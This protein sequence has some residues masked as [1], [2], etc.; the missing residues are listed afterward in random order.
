MIL[1]SGGVDGGTTSHVA[2]LAGL[3]AAS[4]PRSRHGA[5]SRPADRLRRQRRRTRRW[6]RTGSAIRARA[7]GGGEPAAGPRARGARP[8][9][10]G[11]PR[12]LP[13]ARDGAR[14]RATAS[15]SSW[16]TS[17]SS[18]PRAAA[19]RI[20][21]A[22]RGASG[23]RRGRRRR[24]RGDHRRLL[25]PRRRVPPQRLGESRHFLLDVERA[26]RGGRRGDPP[27]AP[28]RRSTSRILR[29]RIR[30]KM[31]RPTT[32][33][34]TWRTSGSSTPS[35]A[36][37]YGSRWARTRMSRSSLRGVQTERTI[38]DVFRRPSAGGALGPLRRV[39]I[40][41]GSGGVLSHAPRRAQAAMILIDVVEPEG[42]HADRRRLD[43]RDAAPRRARGARTRPP[44]RG[45]RDGTA[46]CP[47]G[48]ARPRPAPAARGAAA[49]RVT[50]ESPGGRVER[51]VGFGAIEVIPLG[52]GETARLR[53]EPAK[54]LDIGAGPGA[55]VDAEVAGGEVGL[56]VDARRAA[57]G[58]SGGL[59]AARPP[60]RGV[61]RRSRSLPLT[62]SPGPSVRAFPPGRLTFHYRFLNQR[63]T[64]A[65]SVAMARR[66]IG[67]CP[68][69]WSSRQRGGS[70][71]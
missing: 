41:I 26:G 55:A 44:P 1:L 2:E 45:L 61:G 51:T 34:Q 6:S 70:R 9:A 20:E 71:R 13:R 24:R 31:V 4:N 3:I 65:P 38:S 23:R 7:H 36:R 67:S 28:R 47:S 66:Q 35:R 50:G 32:I 46:S 43:L 37:R 8:R 53:F 17:P 10:A 49:I 21:R 29:D 62:V 52:P 56:I 57:A 59:R 14:P 22:R 69:R 68:K 33:P 40:L 60:H 64:Y 48:R 19:G 5:A 42:A 25:R 12:R 30:N 58:P 39:G 16:T 63:L 18:R 54:G 11:D 27:L 15:S